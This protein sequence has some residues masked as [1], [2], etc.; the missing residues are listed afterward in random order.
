M[1]PE[2]LL[3]GSSP[4]DLVIDLVEQIEFMTRDGPWTPTT[5]TRAITLGRTFMTFYDFDSGPID[6]ASGFANSPEAMQACAAECRLSAGSLAMPWVHVALQLIRVM[7]WP[8]RAVAG[9]DAHSSPQP[10]SPC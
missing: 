5:T 7:T 2:C 3:I 6:G 1:P 8:R 4:N 10:S 9:E